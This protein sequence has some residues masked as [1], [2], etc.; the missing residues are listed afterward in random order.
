MAGSMKWFVYTT[1]NNDTFAL[2]RD[3]SNLE[4]VNGATGDYPATGGPRYSIP[5]NIKPRVITFESVDGLYRR[6][7]VALT[8]AIFNAVVP[9]ATMVDQVSGETLRFVRKKGEI[10]RQPVGE[11]TGITDADAT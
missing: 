9:G 6:D 2:W 1:D 10:L 5:R 8:P 3:E 4:A 11:D 7:I